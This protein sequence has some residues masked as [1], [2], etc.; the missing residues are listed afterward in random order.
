LLAFDESPHPEHPLVTA[1][2]ARTVTLVQALGDAGLD[3]PLWIGSGS[4]D[5]PAQAQVWGLGRVVGLEHPE[6]WGGLVELPP[7]LR[8]QAQS[9][10][11]AV[12]AG[13]DDEDQV[14]V[15]DS[16]LFVRRLAH[17][18]R[19]PD[20]ESW[21]PRG[22]VLVTGGTGALGAHVARWLAGAGADRLVLTS[23]RGIDAPGAAEL[24]DELA[25]LGT[26]VE[27]A[28]CDV[29]DRDALAALVQR[30]AGQGAP[31][32]AVV[33]TAGIGDGAPLA[34]TT[35]AGIA[36]ILAAKVGGAVNLDAVLDEELDAFVLFSSNAG[37]WGSGGLAAYAAANAFLDAFAGQRRARG[38]VATSVAWGLWAGA[39]MAE[40]SSEEFLRRRGLRPMAPESAISALGQALARDETFVAVADVDWVR[41]V[42][43]FTAARPRPLI[44]DLPEVL[45]LAGEDVGGYD[46]T[47]LRTRLAGLPKAERDR[48]LLDLVRTQVAA[49][50]GHASPGAVESASAFRELGFDSLTAVDLRNRLNTATGLKLPSTLVF[51]H[52][53][54]AALAVLLREELAPDEGT[55]PG[56]LAIR[57]ALASLSV[58]E[59]RDAGLLDK[60]LRLAGAA[61]EPEQNSGQFDSIDS[62]DHDD[63]LR[64]ALGEAD[65]A[66][67]LWSS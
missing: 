30:L 7:T 18:Q 24:R 58:A 51:D 59:L 26:E 34:D 44:G 45:A 49:V 61:D 33:H 48:V 10:L 8:E 38:R 28:A 17:A 14:A 4:V 15:R 46:G 1:G 62:M 53:T 43:G 19:R 50:L 11:A 6:R 40:G 66:A 22:T 57:E 12:L 39:G 9:R 25:A 2:L 60:L 56:E 54:P 41:F 65:S 29:A 5:S 64:M 37:V 13:L 23:R 32:R 47:E 35:P 20:V 42:P 16:G 21:R 52:P 67:E 55:D 63:L 3:S 36:E 31:V 27:V